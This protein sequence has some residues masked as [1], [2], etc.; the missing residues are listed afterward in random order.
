MKAAI[1]ALGAWLLVGGSM[2][3]PLSAGDGQLIDGNA[4]TLG[5]RLVDQPVIAV[6]EAFAIDVRACPADVELLGVD[7]VMPAHRHGMNYKPSVTSAGPGRW[8]VEGL[9]WHMRGRWDLA[10]ELRHRGQIQKLSQAIDLP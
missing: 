3:C 1:G 4:V 10:F 2:A 6:S 8:R 7:A 5:W 9:L